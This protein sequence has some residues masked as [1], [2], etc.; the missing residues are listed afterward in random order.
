MDEQPFSSRL[1][2]RDLKIAAY[3]SEELTETA[4]ELTQC[5][6]VILSTIK[7]I[8]KTKQFGTNQSTESR[9]QLNNSLGDVFALVDR[10]IE[11]N[12]ADSER[13]IK[14]AHDKNVRLS[15]WLKRKN[16]IKRKPRA[17][18]GDDCQND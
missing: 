17:I 2:K 8:Q 10:L 6:L 16:E 7:T 11:N 4:T 12:L 18:D 14:R 5:L 15:A 13:I 9:D 3:L 1:S